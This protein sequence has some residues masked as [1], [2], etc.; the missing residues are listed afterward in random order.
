MVGLEASLALLKVAS[1]KIVSLI[2]TEFA[3]IS[4]VTKDLSELQDILGEVT[5][6]L[7]AVRDRATHSDSSLRW[8][9][10][11]RNVMYDIDDL[12]DEVHLETEKHEGKQ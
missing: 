8:I 3:S 1:N 11:L 6:W 9:M 2:T 5:R 10:Q 12:L 7:S 4:G